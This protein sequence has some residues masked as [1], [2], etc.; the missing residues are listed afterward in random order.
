MRIVLDTNCLIQCLS[1]HSAFFAVWESFLNGQN[2]LCVTTDILYEYREILPH[3]FSTELSEAIVN[4]IVNAPFVVHVNPTYRFNLIQTDP[5]DNKIVDC[6]IIAGARYVVTNDHHFN[7]LRE[8]SFPI[9]QI[10]S[11]KDFVSLISR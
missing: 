11:I 3:F 1:S 2:T 8:I 5:D 4:T 7:I 9:V 6:A 10:I